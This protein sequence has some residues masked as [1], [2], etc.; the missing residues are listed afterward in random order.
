[1]KKRFGYLLF[2]AIIILLAG[3]KGKDGKKFTFKQKSN[4]AAYEVLVVID[5]SL[6]NGQVGEKLKDVMS[7]PVPGLPQPEPSLTTSWVA[8]PYFDT[9]L[10]PVR[11]IMIVEISDLYTQAKLTYEKDKWATNQAILYL[12]APDKESVLQFLG[13]NGNYITEYF[14]N[15]ELN[16]ITGVLKE[17]NNQAAAE[18]LSKQLGVEMKIP[19]ELTLINKGENFFWVSNGKNNKRMDIVVYAVPYRDRDAFSAAKI[20]ARRDSVMKKNIPGGPEGSY[21]GTQYFTNENYLD[22]NPVY[23]TFNLNGKF[24]AEMRGLWDVKGDVMGGPFVSHT[25]LD[26]ANNRI[27]TAEAF[28][29]EPEKKKRN[30][31]RQAEAALYTLKLP[32]EK[33]LPEIVITGN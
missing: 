9:M 6:K 26:E 17:N 28:I 1:M 12:R 13:Q 31:M 3:C 21:M 22:L 23:R 32:Y 30:L 24:L 14:V 18:E 25:R 2:T 15:S 19:G 8:T 29:Y 7:M 27:I 11:N 16:R 4:G 10:K 5:E 33:E 20:M